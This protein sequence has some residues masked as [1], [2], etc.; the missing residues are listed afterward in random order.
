[1]PATTVTTAIAASIL[2]VSPAN[3]RRW[4]REGKFDHIEGMDWQR[5]PGFQKQRVYTRD[6][7]VKVAAEIGAEPNLSL[8]D[9]V[10]T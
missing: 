7:I 1:M 3:L 2:G 4:V 6:W 8:F 9:Q 5:R 10:A